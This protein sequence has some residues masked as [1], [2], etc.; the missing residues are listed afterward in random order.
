[1]TTKIVQIKI[2]LPYNVHPEVEVPA[3]LHEKPH[4]PEV[5]S[6]IIVHSSLVLNVLL[7]VSMSVWKNC[8]E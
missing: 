4:G 6:Y 2:H 3:K 5:V 7:T 8:A 1:M